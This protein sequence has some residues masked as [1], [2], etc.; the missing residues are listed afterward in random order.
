M[1]SIESAVFHSPS[2]APWRGQFELKKIFVKKE[3]VE[4]KCDLEIRLAHWPEGVVVKVYKHKALALLPC[5]DNPEIASQYLKK[6]A[7]ASKFWRDTYNFSHRS[8]LDEARYV[9]R[10]GSLMQAAHS[11]TCIEM[12]QQ[13]IEE[14][15]S[16]V[17]S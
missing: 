15:D 9:L 6:E 11:Q 10:N 3:G 12:L 1:E 2:F 8:D 14:I 17:A 16:I 7:V 5:C 4:I 13:F